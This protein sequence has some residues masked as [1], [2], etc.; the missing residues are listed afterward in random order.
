MLAAEMALLGMELEFSLATS[1]DVK[2]SETGHDLNV[3]LGPKVSQHLVRN[4]VPHWILPNP[5]PKN[6]NWKLD[7]KLEVNSITELITFIKNHTQISEIT[8][9]SDRGREIFLP[10]AQLPNNSVETPDSAP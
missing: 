4:N 2:Q 10:T 6:K 1:N 9:G 5:S 8:D 3:A 7:P